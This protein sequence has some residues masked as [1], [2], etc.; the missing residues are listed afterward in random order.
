MISLSLSSILSRIITLSVVSVFVAIAVDFIKY[1]GVKTFKKSKR[2]IVAT[3]TMTMFFLI[4]YLI[5][6][7]QFGTVR[8]Y[9]P[10]IDGSIFIFGPMVMESTAIFLGLIGTLMIAVGAA[11]NILGRLQLKE[12]WANHIKI[13]EEHSLVNYGIYKLVRHP[14]Y[15]SIMLMLFGGSIAY[16]NWVSF[17]LILFIF[18]PFMYYRAKQEEMLLEE[19]FEEYKEYKRTVGMFFPKF[20]IRDRG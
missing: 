1:N 8:V 2:S 6:I 18:I 5:L 16:R 13:Y 12:N 19:E 14:L 15:A 7:L 20:I 3:G 9:N 17:L 4:Y 11:I 10:N